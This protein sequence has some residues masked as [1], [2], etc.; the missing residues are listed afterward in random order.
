M[1]EKIKIYPRDQRHFRGHRDI[2]K[3]K[4]KY[5]PNYVF[6]ETKKKYYSYGITEDERYDSKHKNRPLLS[7]P[8]CNKRYEKSFV[9]KKPRSDLKKNYSTFLYRYSFHPEDKKYIDDKIDKK[10]K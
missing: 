8:N 2:V 10:Y 1:D 3:G 7:N 5:H 9:H 4:I 6:G